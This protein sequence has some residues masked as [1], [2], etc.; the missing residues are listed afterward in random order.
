MGRNSHKIQGDASDLTVA[1]ERAGFTLVYYNATQ[2]WL[3]KKMS[4]Y[5]TLKEDK[6]KDNTNIVDSGTEGTKIATGTTAQRWIN[7]RS[8][9]I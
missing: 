4:N 7:S 9:K 2:G 5:K 6:F 8:D 3:L 1:V